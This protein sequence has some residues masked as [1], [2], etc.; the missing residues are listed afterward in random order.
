M[1][2]SGLWARYD[3]RVRYTGGRGRAPASAGALGSRYSGAGAVEVALQRVRASRRA[4]PRARADGAISWRAA[5]AAAAR[6]A[7]TPPAAR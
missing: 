6:A 5:R 2:A 7:R 1:R 3:S 4:P